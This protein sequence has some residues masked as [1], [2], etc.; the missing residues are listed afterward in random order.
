MIRRITFCVNHWSRI[1]MLD[2]GR[3]N[4]ICFHPGY[5]VL[6]GPN[7]TGKTTVLEAIAGCPSCKKDAS[8]EHRVRYITSESLNPL[9]GARFRTREEMVLGIRA[10]FSSHGEAVRGTLAFQRY[11]G[12]DCILIDTPET[13]QDI[14]E[15]Q[16]IHRRLRRMHAKYG[17]QVIVATHSPVFLQGADR[18][19]ELERRYFRRVLESNRKI[20]G[21][22][23]RG[24]RGA[25]GGRRQR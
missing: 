18:I 7:A 20:L 4:E 3:R 25:K 2:G 14:E 13:A 5:N 10:L 21:R 1:R 9:A 24:P 15:S 19:V 8:A 17:I 12:E 22:L 23:A 11:D 6:I 16:T